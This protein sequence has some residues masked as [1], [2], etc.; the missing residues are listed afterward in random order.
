MINQII[1][2]STA[3]R[4][5]YFPEGTYYLK[6]ILT[7]TRDGVRLVGAGIDKTKFYQQNSE[8]RFR[9]RR[10]NDLVLPLSTSPSRGGAT[11]HTTGAN[12]IKVGDFVQPLAKFPWGGQ[13]DKFKNEMENVGRGQITVVKEIEGDQISVSE[14]I[15]LDFTSW[16]DPRLHVVTMLKDVGMESIHIEKLQA[17]NKDTVEFDRVTNA[18][19]KGVRFFWTH[20]KTIEVRRSYR[21]FIENCN[22]SQGWDKT[23][24]GMSY[25]IHFSV[26]TTRCYAINNKLKQL[27]HAIVLQ[28]GANHCVVAYNHT[29][30]NILLH[31]NYAHNNLIEGNVASAGINFDAVHGANGPYNFIFRNVASHESKGIGKLNGAAPNVVIGNVSDNYDVRDD[32][33]QAANRSAGIIDWGSLPPNPALPPSLLYQRFPIFLEGRWW[34]LFGPRVGSDWGY[35]NTNPAADREIASIPATDLQFDSDGDNVDDAWETAHFATLTATDGNPDSDADGTSDYDEFVAGTNP[36]DGSNSFGIREIQSDPET[37]NVTLTLP[38]SSD[39]ASRSYQ[40]LH[41]ANLAPLTWQSEPPFKPTS[42]NTTEQTI[43][44]PIGTERQFFQARA[45]LW[46]EEPSSESL[47][48]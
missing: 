43:T 29:E 19:L 17:D 34:P 20:A 31:G 24:G 23:S 33:Y 22:I 6:S 35:T 10:Q 27:R 32:D 14:P 42:A 15:G 1:N 16:P 3:Y 12:Q 45:M 21:L 44:L 39:R 36:L 13:E 47:A 25:G 37:G 5:L 9:S 41:S 7:I 46:I 30:S 38:T 28:Q 8:I 4:I 18:Y 48:K 2:S 26:N 40:I 11:L